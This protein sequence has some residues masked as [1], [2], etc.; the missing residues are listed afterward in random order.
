[1][2]PFHWA[3]SLVLM[4]GVVAVKWWCGQEFE[5]HECFRSMSSAIMHSN[6]IIPLVLARSSWSTCSQ[7]AHSS[8][9]IKTDSPRKWPADSARTQTRAASP[10]VSDG[11]QAEESS[12]AKTV[13]FANFQA[14][15]NRTD[16]CATSNT[17]MTFFP[18]H[19]HHWRVV[20]AIYQ[21]SA[22]ESD[23]N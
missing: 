19:Q 11:V 3:L 4:G 9:K 13:N 10:G 17:A 2:T 14:C 18:T 12:V 21:Q 6:L 8:P 23:S 5:F 15:L 20:F 16:E 22:A 1:M 7:L